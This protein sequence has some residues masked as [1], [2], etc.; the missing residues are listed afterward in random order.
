[1][2]NIT[3]R[4]NFSKECEDAIN[5]QINLELHASNIYLSLSSFFKHPDNYLENTYKFFEHNSD[6]ERSHAKMFI[7]YV[8]K[9]GGTT[10]IK[11]IDE[12]DVDISNLNLLNAFEFSLDLEKKVNN[13]LLKLHQLASNM[14]DPQLTDFIEGTFLKEQVESQYEL[15]TIV[16]NIRRCVSNYGSLGEFI[17]DKN[18][19]Y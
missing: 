12:P 18:F 1:M 11:K 4:Q 19:I 13:N 8:N 10:C 14:N 5:D 9:R 6:E 16:T 2:N 17:F 7:D 3:C 15:H